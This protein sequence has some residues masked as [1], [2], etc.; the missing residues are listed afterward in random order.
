MFVKAN[1]RNR[2]DEYKNQA[3][4]MAS[5][6]LPSYLKKLRLEAIDHKSVVASKLWH[7]NPERKVDWD[8]S[9]SK[10]YCSRY[11]KSFDLSIWNQNTLISLSLGRPTFKGTSMR[12]DFVERTPDTDVYSGRIFT[13]T[14]LAYETYGRLIGAEFIRI[15]EPMNEKLIHHYTS[16][17][18]GFSLVSAKQGVPHYLVKKL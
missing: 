17:D 5:D 1:V 7:K 3:R 10:N 14:R 18:R 9:D 12:L 4:E 13:I 16:S 15:M 11:P 2:Y 6:A 8:W